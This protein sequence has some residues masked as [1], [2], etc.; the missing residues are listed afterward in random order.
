MSRRRRGIA[1]VGLGMAVRP[2]A[3]SLLDL[4]NIAALGQQKPALR[5]VETPEALR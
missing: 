2:H 5:L 1:V 4:G 3:Q